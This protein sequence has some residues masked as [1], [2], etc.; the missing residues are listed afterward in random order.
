MGRGTPDAR[1]YALP[2]LPVIHDSSLF[3][4]LTSVLPALTI[5]ADNMYVSWSLGHMLHQWLDLIDLGHSGP[6]LLCLRAAFE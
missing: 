5:H 3:D 1:V 6:P 4:N 2:P